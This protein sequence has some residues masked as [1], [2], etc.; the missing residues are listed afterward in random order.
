MNF[1]SFGIIL[2]LFAG[3]VFAFLVGHGANNLARHE[4][5]TGTGQYP[6]NSPHT[7][8][9]R[10]HSDGNF[11]FA[12]GQLTAATAGQYITQTN[13]GMHYAIHSSNVLG[14]LRT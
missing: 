9:S 12:G 13:A 8:E 10:Y 5:S 2:A 3:R 11:T 7:I 6:G 14:Q 1:H 4:Y